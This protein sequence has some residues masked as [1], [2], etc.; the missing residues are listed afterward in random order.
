[1]K[2]GELQNGSYGFYY[3]GAQAITTQPAQDV[4]KDLQ[5]VIQ[6]VVTVPREQKT[7][8]PYNE[9]ITSKS[10]SVMISG[11]MYWLHMV[12]SLTKRQRW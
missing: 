4:L 7:A 3:K 5:S 9:A 12:S 10:I 1:M 11:R 8:T 2:P 6:P